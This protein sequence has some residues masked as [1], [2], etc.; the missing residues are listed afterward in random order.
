[1]FSQMMMKPKKQIWGRWWWLFFMSKN[2]KK[3]D[4]WKN[5][6]FR[7][8]DQYLFSMMMMAKVTIILKELSKQQ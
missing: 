4:M 8:F 7:K 1:M 5:L 6:D 2:K 3:E